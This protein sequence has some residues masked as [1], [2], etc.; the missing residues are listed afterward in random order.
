MAIVFGVWYLVFGVSQLV[1]GVLSC[2]QIELPNTSPNP[3]HQTRNTKHKTSKHQ[4]PNTKH[5]FKKGEYHGFRVD[6]AGQ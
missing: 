1:F 5:N 3:K 6:A 2:R 4:T